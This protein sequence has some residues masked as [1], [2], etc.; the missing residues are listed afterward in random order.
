MKKKFSIVLFT[1]F[2]ATA[3]SPLAIFA[4]EKEK[5]RPYWAEDGLMFNSKEVNVFLPNYKN[6]DSGIFATGKGES[7]FLA[8]MQSLLALTE[9]STKFSIHS[10]YNNDTDSSEIFETRYTDDISPFSN[11]IESYTDSDGYVYTL[12]FISDENIRKFIQGKSPSPYK[13]EV[14]YASTEDSYSESITYSLSQ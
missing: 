1:I 10:I 13:V 3:F 4:K 9:F 6:S 5:P 2:V 11:L 12:M 7:L 14:V 8:M